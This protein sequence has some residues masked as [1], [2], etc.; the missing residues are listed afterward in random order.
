MLMIILFPVFI[1]SF[2][3]SMYP[4]AFKIS[5]GYSKLPRAFEPRQKSRKLLSVSVN[6]PVGSNRKS[7]SNIGR[8]AKKSKMSISVKGIAG[9][10]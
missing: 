10:Y 9:E 2:M 5:I 3:V 7:S 1:E 4:H 8:K 6:E